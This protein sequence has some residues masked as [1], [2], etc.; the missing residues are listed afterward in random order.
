MRKTA[1]RL[2]ESSIRTALLAW[3]QKRLSGRDLMIEELGVEHGSARVDVA[4]ASSRLAGYEIKSDFDT[5]DRLARQM[6]TYQRVFDALTIV[7]TAAFVDEVEALL[8][9]SWGVIIARPSSLQQVTLVQRRQ[10]T[11]NKRQDATSV[12]AMLWRDEAYAFLMEQCG[13]VVR[14]NAT[15]G[16]IYEALAM[17]VPP[18]A[19]RD[20]VL[21]TLK[22]RDNAGSRLHRSSG[23]LVHSER[24]VMVGGV[25]PPCHEAA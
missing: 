19:I 20:R 23:K 10:A 17:R 13:A 15:R 25:P 16:E 21:E 22:A 8:P 12:A 24:Q 7:T 1:D 3:L 4:I 14:A 9:P 6:H 2:T 11:P 5:L 18:D